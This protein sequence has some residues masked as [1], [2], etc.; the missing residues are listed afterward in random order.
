M[1]LQF[2]HLYGNSGHNLYF[3]GILAEV[4]IYNHALSQSEIQQIYDPV[5]EHATMFLLGSNLVGLAGFRR[6]K[7][8]K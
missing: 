4:R 2:G 5:P 6:K 3:E 7:F 8:K 1:P